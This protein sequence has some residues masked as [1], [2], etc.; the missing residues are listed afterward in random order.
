[1]KDI[2]E[3]GEQA[4]PH[5]VIALVIYLISMQQAA[6]PIGPAEVSFGLMITTLEFGTLL[7]FFRRNL[8]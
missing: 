6:L 2:G 3:R 8:L 7:S 4:S 5:I 1:M